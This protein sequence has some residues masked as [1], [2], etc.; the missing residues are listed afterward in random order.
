LP[1]LSTVRQA[2]AYFIVRLPNDA[3]TTRSS[4][5]WSGRAAIVHISHR[6]DA[7]PVLDPAEDVFDL[8]APAIEFGVVV[9]LNLAVFAG[10]DA[11]GG[12]LRDQRGAEPVAA[13]SFVGEQLL[14]AGKR[15]K[16]QGSVSLTLLS[17]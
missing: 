4:T 3:A 15:G 10:R 12:V 11:W 14:G 8:V 7:A 6:S 1:D 13:I 5:V 9:V 16:Q 17:N 2:E